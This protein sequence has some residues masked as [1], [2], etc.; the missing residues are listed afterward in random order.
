LLLLLHATPGQVALWTG[1]TLVVQYGSL[2]IL[3]WLTAT[4]AAKRLS[5][6]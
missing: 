4:F 1:V 2:A 5:L 3:S 6:R